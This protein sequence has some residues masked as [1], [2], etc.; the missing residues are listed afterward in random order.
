MTSNVIFP[1]TWSTLFLETG[2]TTGTPGSL[3]RLGWLTSELP[4]PSLLSQVTSTYHT[5]P[6]M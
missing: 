5:G 6:F 2:S 4:E 3:I 1:Q